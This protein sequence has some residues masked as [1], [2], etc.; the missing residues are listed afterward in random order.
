MT[1]HFAE[2]PTNELTNPAYDPVAKIPEFKVTAVKVSPAEKAAGKR[3]TPAAAG[4]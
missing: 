2:T 1:F 4:K 3:Q